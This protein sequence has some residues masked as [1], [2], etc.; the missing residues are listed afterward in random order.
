[1]IPLV[2]LLGAFTA[3][4][5][6]AAGAEAA[7]SG[8]SAG[9]MWQPEAIL[10]GRRSRSLALPRSCGTRR[11]SP[12]MPHRPRAPGS[13]PAGALLPVAILLE[14]GCCT[15]ITSDFIAG[16]LFWLYKLLA[17]AKTAA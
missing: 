7:M 3:Q 16:R 17:G 1:V 14:R 6:V 13:V 8:M 2:S 12:L 10:G 5:V 9:I 11:S 4:F 15:R